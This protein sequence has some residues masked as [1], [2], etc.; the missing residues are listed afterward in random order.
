VPL[1][2]A[3]Q[4]DELIRTIVSLVSARSGRLVALTLAGSVPDEGLPRIQERLRRSGMSDVDVHVRPAPGP[5]RVLTLEF[6]R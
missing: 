3:N 4:I 1:P 6:E 5:L 2:I